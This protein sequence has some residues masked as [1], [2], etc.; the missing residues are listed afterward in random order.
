[1][2]PQTL[3]V[4]KDRLEDS[5]QGRKFFTPEEF[6]TLELL[7]AFVVPHAG[8]SRIDLA[9]SI[10]HQ[11]HRGEGPG[12]RY[13]ALPPN[14]EAYRTALGLL[15]IEFDKHSSVEEPPTHSAGHLL[16]L[17]EAVQ[18]KEHDT[19]EFALSLWFENCKTD[20]VRFW[21]AA[22]QT[23]G[24]MQ[25]AGFADDALRPQKSGSTR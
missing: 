2:S 16:S 24:Q 14:A 11:L 19:P 25:Y 4:L 9:L 20:L 5:K 12:W 17:L 8:D 22:P 6:E 23:M 15:K 18:R 1:M 13:A 21:L 7:A 3:T 10:D